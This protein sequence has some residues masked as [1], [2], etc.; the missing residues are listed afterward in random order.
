MNFVIFIEQISSKPKRLFIEY[1]WEAILGIE[2]SEKIFIN[3]RLQEPERA[4]KLKTDYATLS[5][6][7]TAMIVEYF[8]TKKYTVLEIHEMLNSYTSAKS[9]RMIFKA[10][11]SQF[12]RDYYDENSHLYEISGLDIDANLQAAKWARIVREILS[13]AENLYNEERMKKIS[14]K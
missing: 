3:I 9:W 1:N 12:V 11:M 4:I 5:A 13:Y 2:P 10:V 14:I 8:Y 7:T 6:Y